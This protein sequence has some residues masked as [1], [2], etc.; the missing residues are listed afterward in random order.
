MTIWY[1]NYT[2][3]LLESWY[4]YYFSCIIF[5]QRSSGE[6][7]WK[8]YGYLR[9][10]KAEFEYDNRPRYSSL[11]R[12]AIDKICMTGRDVE[13]IAAGKFCRFYGRT[14]GEWGGEEIPCLNKG[15]LYVRGPGTYVAP[16]SANKCDYSLDTLIRGI[17]RNLYR[18]SDYAQ[19]RRPSLPAKLFSPFRSCW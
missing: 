5:Y 6:D 16:F 7:W 8:I 9:Y 19:S 14:E 4:F 10:L 18:S 2:D 13:G 17:G 11:W 1:S 15:T 3:S 12:R